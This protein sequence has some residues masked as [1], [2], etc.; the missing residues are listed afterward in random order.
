MSDVV[1]IVDDSLTV[2]MDLTEAFESAGFHPRPCRTLEEARQALGGADVAVV[3]LDVLLPDGD[4]IELLR[5]LRASPSM[6]DMPVLLLSTETEVRD[7]VRGLSVGADEYVGKPYDR[8]YVVARARQLLHRHQGARPQMPAILLVDDSMTFRTELCAALEREGYSVVEAATGE[9]A[10]AAAA[11]AAPQAVVVD[12][13]L[14]GIDGATVVRR[15]RLDAALRRTPCVLLTASDVPGAELGALEAGADAFVRKDD[16]IPVILARLAAVLRATP[17]WESG[18]EPDS[19]LGPKRVLAVDDSPTFLHELAAALQGEGYDVVLARSGEDALDLLAVQPVDCVLLDLLM[20]GLSG[21]ETCRRIK[22]APVIRDIPLI[23]LTA[24]EDREAM[25]A[26]LGAGADD[27]IA[28]SADLEVLKARVRA[29]LRR[30]QFEEE[31]RRIREQLLRVELEAAEARVAREL[32]EVRAALVQELERKNRELEAF[33]YSVSHDLR[34][35]LRGLEG[36]SR[37]LEAQAADLDE[38][39]RH[40]LDRI[41]SAARRMSELIDGLL[42]LSRVGRAELSRAPVD[43]SAL[44]RDVAAELERAEPDRS[45]RVT[46]QEDLAAEGDR[47]LLRI[48]LENLLGNAFKFTAKTADAA[49][50]LGAAE[51]EGQ[52]TYFVRDNGAGFDSAYAQRLFAPFQRLHDES[53]FPGTGIG[54][55]T[56][57]R[58]VERHGGR[59]WAEGVV[60]LGATL[61]WTLG[62]RRASRD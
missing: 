39:S 58:I 34:A 52:R 60:G 11:D 17:L 4:G 62:P 44:A 29:Q 16:G 50:E 51:S 43:L 13:V 3:V 55:A 25:I 32:A 28:K 35:P 18:S 20:P 38:K 1:L 5:E 48:A 31:H 33:S 40:Y 57:H 47:R 12:G 46:I 8:S 15:L 53:D 49:V 9:E 42:A 56:V 37:L 7:R 2:R 54:L 59:V 14:P 6:Q 19:V 41:R 23:M 22:G 26:G 24:V 36:F 61:F 10:L 27:Y 45:V 30:R 21:E